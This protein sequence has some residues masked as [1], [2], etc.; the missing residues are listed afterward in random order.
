LAPPLGELSAKL[1]ER[2]VLQFSAFVISECLLQQVPHLCCRLFLYL[3]R[4]MGVGGEGESG[5]AVPKYAGYGLDIDA[6]LQ[7]KGCEGMPQIMEA[8]VLQSG[9]LEDLLMELYHRIGMVHFSGHRR[10][11]ATRPPPGAE[12]GRGASGSGRRL[13]SPLRRAKKTP[14]TATGNW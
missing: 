4:S 10:G 11:G 9:I 3:V 1:T 13:S 6:I 14:G 5:A 12:E 2:V 8:D 7:G